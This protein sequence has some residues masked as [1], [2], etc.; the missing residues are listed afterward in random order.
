MGNTFDGI[1]L[2]STNS[3]CAINIEIPDKE[4]VNEMVEKFYK[5]LRKTLTSQNTTEEQYTFLSEEL[6]IA[7]SKAEVE[8]IF[9]NAREKGDAHC[10]VVSFNATLSQRKYDELGVVSFKY[11]SWSKKAWEKA[12]KAYGNP[13]VKKL[14]DCLI[15]ELISIACQVLKAILGF[16]F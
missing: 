6:H 5:R 8:S 3:Y 16:P 1:K 12:K 2:D 9:R 4:L 13:I 7:T 11:L 15:G 14:I 10:I